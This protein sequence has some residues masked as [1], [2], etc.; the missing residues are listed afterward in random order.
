ML[1]PW[2]DRSVSMYHVYTLYFVFVRVYAVLNF[3]KP[4]Y[5]PT[6]PQSANTTRGRPHPTYVGP[7]LRQLYHKNASAHRVYRPAG[8]GAAVTLGQLPWGA[9]MPPMEAAVYKMGVP[10]DRS[11]THPAC[12][13]KRVRLPTLF[14]TVRVTKL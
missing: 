2:F 1:G 10:R 6:L 12:L 11:R 13:Q 7:V 9:T 5:L 4:V 8:G 14:V 3:A